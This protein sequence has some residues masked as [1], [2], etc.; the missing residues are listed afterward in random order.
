MDAGDIQ[1]MRMSWNYWCG[2]LP[3]SHSSPSKFEYLQVQLMQIL[4]KVLWG[5][6][7]Y[8]QAQLFTLSHGLNNPNEWH[9]VIGTIF[10]ID[11]LIFLI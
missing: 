7:K 11:L 1:L 8:W 10:F 5:I 2:K 3:S 6:Q 4:K 9:E